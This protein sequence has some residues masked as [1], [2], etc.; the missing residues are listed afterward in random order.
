ML[1]SANQPGEGKLIVIDGKLAASLFSTSHRHAFLGESPSHLP[2]PQPASS[3]VLSGAHDEMKMN[4]A[5]KKSPAP[6]AAAVGCKRESGLENPFYGSLEP[7]I[8]HMLA[9][10][11]CAVDQGVERDIDGAAVGG[12]GGDE[13]GLRGAF[14]AGVDV[15]AAGSA[16]NP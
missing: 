4:Q 8:E 6:E 5:N 15:V 1:T 11:P 16:T 14:G 10:L 2:N 13:A 9:A 7:S 3:D 12:E